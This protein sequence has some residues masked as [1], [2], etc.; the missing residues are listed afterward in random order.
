MLVHEIPI[1]RTLSSQTDIPN[2]RNPH[3]MDDELSLRMEDSNDMV[4]A[5]PMGKSCIHSM[6]N[7]ANSCV[8]KKTTTRLTKGANGRTVPHTQRGD[9]A[10]WKTKNCTLHDQIGHVPPASMHAVLLD[11][12]PRKL[13]KP[14]SPKAPS[15]PCSQTTISVN[16]GL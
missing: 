8:P 2:R 10:A 16:K 7:G 1:R 6:E 9:V 5:T 13:H 3:E 11:V 15:E 14:K 12:Y 4:D